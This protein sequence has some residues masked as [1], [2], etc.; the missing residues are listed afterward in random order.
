[1]KR[2]LAV[3]VAMPALLRCA[4]PGEAPSWTNGLPADPSFFPVGVW[5]QDPAFAP[6]YRDLGINLCVGTRSLSRP[7]QLEPLR[8]AGMRAIL[9]ADEVA[10]RF[11]GEPHVV[12]WMQEDEPD[13]A[14][15]LGPCQGYGPPVPPAEVHRRYRRIRSDDPTRPVL[16]NLGP[17]AAWDDAPARG[18]RRG[19]PEDYAEYAGGGDILS[20]NFSPV[21]REEPEVSGR[22]EF[23]AR[24]VDRLRSA[25][26][27][28]KPVWAFIE[29]TPLRDGTRRPSP[30]AVRAEVWMSLLHG[31][32]GIV[33]SAHRFR[34]RFEEAALLA[35]EAMARAVAEINRQIHELAPVLN[36]PPICGGLSVSSP[37]PVDAV[38]KRH[39]GAPM[40]W[41]PR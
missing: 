2:L 40:S 33:Y 1:M 36:A 18:P 41:L 25:S 16:L 10:D 39:G 30:R 7:E 27:G 14:Q 6:K 12:G 31:A 20:F 21:N 23:M 35:D 22:L 13:S 34:P 29:T 24:G 17:G 26:G 28:R 3:A 19:H 4:G 9:R 8:E 32:R 5:L 11:R 38:A 15:L 37:V